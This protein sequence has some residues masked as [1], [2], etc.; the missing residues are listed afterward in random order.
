MKCCHLE[1]A[2]LVIFICLFLNE[3]GD[4]CNVFTYVSKENR[5]V[6]F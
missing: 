1:F 6:D 5:V 3:V 4:F 2:M